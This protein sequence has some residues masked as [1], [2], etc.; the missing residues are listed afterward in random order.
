M[1]QLNAIQP[2]KLRG[3][4][5]CGAAEI[6]PATERTEPM[7]THKDLNRPIEHVLG[8]LNMLTPQLASG[9]TLA[10]VTTVAGLCDLEVLRHTYVYT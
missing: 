8:E 10:N 5:N 7:I 1:V 3:A 6:S 4:W 2:I 9:L